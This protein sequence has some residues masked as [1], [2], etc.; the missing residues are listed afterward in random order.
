MDPKAPYADC[1]RCPLRDEHFVPGYGRRQA[2]RVIVGP[3]PGDKE[4]REGK[5]FVGPAGE[6]LNQ[7]LVA[8]G[9]NRSRIYM[10]NTVLCR[11]P[12]HNPPPEAVSAC[13]KRLIHEVQ[14]TMPRR[15]LALG[16]IASKALT[17]DN[18][19]V[20][21]MR[22]CDRLPIRTWSIANCR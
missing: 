1:D 22:F 20:K 13:F 9:A 8:R 7:A 2:G 11:P 17:G 16:E 6:R 14:G 5:P 10:T 3:G 18:R 15:V 21:E 4:V 19:R 12:N